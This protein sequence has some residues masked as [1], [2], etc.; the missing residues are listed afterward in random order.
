MIIGISHLAGKN[1]LEAKTDGKFLLLK[2][3][4]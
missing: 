2:A 3:K 4:S 1:Q